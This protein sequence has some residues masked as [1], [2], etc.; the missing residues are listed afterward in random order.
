MAF[1]IEDYTAKSTVI[2]VELKNKSE[3]LAWVIGAFYMKEDNDMLAF[4]QQLLMA[5]ISL[6]NPIERLNPQLFLV[7]QPIKSMT[8]YLEPL[9]LGTQKMKNLMLVEKT[10]LAQFGIAVFHLQKFGATD[11][12]SCLT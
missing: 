10:G 9:V 2:D 12:L 6:I 5:M 11:S 7:K 4:F 3:D 8:N 1:V